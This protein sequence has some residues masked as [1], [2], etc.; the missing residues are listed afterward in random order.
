MRPSCPF[1]TLPEAGVCLSVSVSVSEYASGGAG[2]K[3]ATFQL[4]KKTGTRREE[5]E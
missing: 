2:I 1:F 5:L 4:K 3:W